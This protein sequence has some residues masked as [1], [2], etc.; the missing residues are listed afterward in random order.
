MQRI[1]LN[2][3]TRTIQSVY[4]DYI[5]DERLLDYDFN[6]VKKNYL[7][8]KGIET[9]TYDLLIKGLNQVAPNILTVKC[10][11]CGESIKYLNWETYDKH[12]RRC[13]KIDFINRQAKE[14]KG[15]GIDYSIYRSMSDE[16]LN[17]RYRKIMDYY[18]TTHKDITV[19]TILK[20]L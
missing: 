3:L 12:W 15:E 5:E 18:Q 9:P 11:Y 8:H 20:T 1:E 19:N 13:S 10:E 16:E 17:Q 14:L 2:N 7:H 4:S 6:E